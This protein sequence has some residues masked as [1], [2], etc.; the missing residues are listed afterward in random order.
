MVAWTSPSLVADALGP[1]AGDSF[2]TDPYSG[3]VVAASNAVCFRKRAEAGYVD[4]P[5]PTASA[6]SEDVAMG[7]TLYAV[8]LWRERAST[9]GYPSFEDLSS[10]TP[11]GG[12]WGQVKRLLGIGKAQVDTPLTATELVEARRRVLARRW[13]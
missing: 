7:A 12:S 3:Q 13:L 9:D 1:G 6:P 11:T 10:F 2:L 4:P 5:D 8:A